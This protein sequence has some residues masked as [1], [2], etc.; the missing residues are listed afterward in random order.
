M[1]IVR[2]FGVPTAAALVLT[3]C[4]CAAEAKPTAVFSDGPSAAPAS[5]PPVGDI[6][7]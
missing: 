1:N 7:N 2:W 4:G 3:V 6:R 5:D